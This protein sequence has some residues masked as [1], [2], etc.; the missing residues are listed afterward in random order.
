MLSALIESLIEK[1]ATKGIDRLGHLGGKKKLTAD[2]KFGAIA[3]DAEL[4][5]GLV[6]ALKDTPAEEQT[7][8]ELMLEIQIAKIR[9]NAQAGAAIFQAADNI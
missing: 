8:V 9:A 7:T 6:D 3:E 1:A 5:L 2:L 4:A